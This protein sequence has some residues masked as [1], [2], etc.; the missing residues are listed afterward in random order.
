MLVRERERD[1]EIEK[2]NEVKNGSVQALQF[3]AL[4]PSKTKLCTVTCFNSVAPKMSEHDAVQNISDI[5]TSER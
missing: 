3:E 1:R 2:K 4:Q 5:V